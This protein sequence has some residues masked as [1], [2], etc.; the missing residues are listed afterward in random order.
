MEGVG[1]GVVRGGAMRDLLLRCYFE[2]CHAKHHSQ[3]KKPC[4]VI[5]T[6]KRRRRL[7]RSPTLAYSYTRRANVPQ[8]TEDTLVLGKTGIGENFRQLGKDAHLRAA[9]ADFFPRRD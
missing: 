8:G 2:T 4:K 7:V 5:V 1:V 9:R 3:R 6:L